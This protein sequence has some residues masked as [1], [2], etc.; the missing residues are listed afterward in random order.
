MRK[1]KGAVRLR[2]LRVVAFRMLALDRLEGP[3][4]ILKLRGTLVGNGGEAAMQRVVRRKR[5]SVENAV[6][7]SM[8]GGWD[9]R[10]CMGGIVKEDF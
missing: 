5:T 3:C 8:V 9:G 4:G 6:G 2:V 10:R 1:G 7:R